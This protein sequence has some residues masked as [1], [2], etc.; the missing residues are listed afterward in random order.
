V[1]YILELLAS[2][3]KL[4]DILADR[5]QIFVEGL[6]TAFEYT[7]ASTR[8]ELSNRFWATRGGP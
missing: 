1:F 4:D 3:A 2:G 8:D 5:S 6:T 7:A